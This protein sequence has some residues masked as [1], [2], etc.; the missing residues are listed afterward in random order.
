MQIC[1]EKFVWVIINQISKIFVHLFSKG[2][3]A[4]NWYF[5][6]GARGIC[7]NLFSTTS[8][9]P[10]TSQ[11]H[12]PKGNGEPISKSTEIF[13]VQVRVT[14]RIHAIWGLA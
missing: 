14:I 11:P 1:M 3:I 9:N 6:D 10:K 12:R 8:A 5:I 2:E 13:P 7:P 4:T